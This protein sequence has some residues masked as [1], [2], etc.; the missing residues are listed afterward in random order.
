MASFIAKI[1]RMR[2][3]RLHMAN[4][5]FYP[6]FSMYHEIIQGIPWS[7]GIERQ[8]P[9]KIFTPQDKFVKMALKKRPQYKNFPWAAGD[10]AG[11]CI[12][13]GNVLGI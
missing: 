1:N 11:V 8:K 10:G 4:E 5:Y 2:N 6:T 7:G 13:D 3:N 9:K 12:L